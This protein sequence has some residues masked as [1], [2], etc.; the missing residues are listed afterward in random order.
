MPHAMPDTCFVWTADT[1]PWQ[2]TS[3]DG[4]RFALLEGRRDVPGGAYTYAAFVPKGVWSKAHFHTQATRLVVLRGSLWL[5]FGDKADRASMTAYP[6]GSYLMVPGGTRH[7]DGA[8]ED[9]VVIATAIG[10]SET[11][12]LEK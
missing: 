2:E 6:V 7:F 8:E 12:H 11:V 1:I 3:A 9:T 10:V 4:S 5:G